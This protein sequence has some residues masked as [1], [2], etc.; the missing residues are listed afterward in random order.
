MNGCLDEIDIQ[1]NNNF[2]NCPEVLFL[3]LKGMTGALA[4]LLVI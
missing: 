1:T 3:Y 4:H 2:F